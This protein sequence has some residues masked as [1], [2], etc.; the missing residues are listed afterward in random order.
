MKEKEGKGFMHFLKTNGSGLLLCL[1]I[2][3]PSWILGNLFPVIGGAVI[4]IL[5]GM[6]IALRLKNQGTLAPGIKFTS[7]KILQ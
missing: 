6:L 3:V 5:I 1:A 4:A 2:A 7:K